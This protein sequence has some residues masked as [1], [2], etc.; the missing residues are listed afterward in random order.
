M[1]KVI[2][3]LLAA[4]LS[5]C[6]AQQVQQVLDEYLDTSQAEQLTTADVSAGLKEALIKGVSTGSDQASKTDGFFKNPE[7]K[8]PFPPEVQK[9]EN[10]L[11]D[12][13]MN[14]LVDDFVQSLNRGAEQAA[15]E[16][17][18]I[19]ISAVRGMTIQDAWNILK[20]EDKE[21]ATNYLRRTT[22]KALYNSF[23][24]VIG[25]A[26]EKTNATR[27]YGDIVNTYNKIPF[28]EKV[29]PDLTDYATNKA[30]DG[31]FLLIAKEEKAIRQ[32]PV[33]RTTDLLRRVF[34]AQD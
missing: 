14:K 4:I 18:P 29:N 3:F 33:K 7:I 34:K 31:L 5:G 15:A 17:K 6:T 19:F 1:Q 20:G 28:V 16:A 2:W 13:G 30:M 10:K 12:L 11:R 22:S 8:I 21:A 9:V 26:L 24:P 23:S 32:D 27:Y 25:N